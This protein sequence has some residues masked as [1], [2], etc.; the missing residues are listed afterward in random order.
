[1]GHCVDQEMAQSQ[2]N[3]DL[4]TE[5]ARQA[6]YIKWANFFGIPDPCGYYKGFIR[7]MAIHIKYIHSSI[8][9][10]N[11]QIQF[12]ATVQGYAKAVN[13][14][15][16]LRSF[17]PPANLSDLNNMTAILLNN[18]LREEDIARLRAP[19][20][21]KSFAKLCQ[22]AT[23]SKCKDSVSYLLFFV[24]A[25]SRYIGPCLSKYA[26]TTQDKVD[27][28]TYPSVKTV[29]KAFI[30]NDFIFYDE[31]KSIIKE[32]NKDSLQ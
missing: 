4:E 9:Y 25:L 6:H 10:N 16:K 8:N 5:A 21:N 27:H 20:D 14:V 2:R 7:I 3:P 23:A 22:M 12:S 19:L 1:M 24:M 18:M 29:I 15:F 28:H 17:S 11:K 26:Q 13:N 30:A 32:L 31:R